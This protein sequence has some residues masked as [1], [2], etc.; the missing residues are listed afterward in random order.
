MLFREVHVV[1]G[2]GLSATTNLASYCNTRD[3]S[4][5]DAG[6]KDAKKCILRLK[7]IKSV[8][9][10][11]RDFSQDAGNTTKKNCKLHLKKM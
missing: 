4:S 5:E 11:P 3:A 1:A 8:I 9:T 10:L 7:K 2:R 6:N